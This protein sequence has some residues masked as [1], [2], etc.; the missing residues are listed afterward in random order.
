[1]GAVGAGLFN[2]NIPGTDFPS[3]NESMANIRI[4]PDEFL[5]YRF[6]RGSEH[7]HR[8][9]RWFSQRTSQDQLPPVARFS[10]QAKVFLF[11][12]GG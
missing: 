11:V 8:F 2:Y 6:V 10:G 1:M 9:I 12:P 5:D 4:V 3:W 7:K